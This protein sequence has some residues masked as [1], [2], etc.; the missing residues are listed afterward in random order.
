M[1]LH[2][3]SA[4]W[5]QSVSTEK[6]LHFARS[7]VSDVEAFKLVPRYSLFIGSYFPTFR[8]ILVPYSESKISLSLLEILALKM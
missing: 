4:V 8:T 1:C 5:Y 2:L 7:S 3:L 6:K